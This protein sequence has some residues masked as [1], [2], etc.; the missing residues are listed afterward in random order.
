[1]KK[2]TVILVAVLVLAFALAVFRLEQGQ[3]SEQRRLLEE[4]IR[5]I[6]VS[7]YSLEGYYPP[8][9]AYMTEHYGLT[10]DENAYR[11]HYEIYAT[12]LMPD[13]TVLE[14]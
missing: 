3:Q 5:R 4:R 12:N 6:A 1:M 13:I 7:C 11:I 9:L 10:Y 2:R 8:S 14:K